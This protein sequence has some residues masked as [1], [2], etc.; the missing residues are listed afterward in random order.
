MCWL[1]LVSQ[2]FAMK[3]S[4]VSPD[5]LTLTALDTACREETTHHRHG[6]PS[7][8][9]F[10]MEIF[11]RAL[12]L[13]A[14]RDT[15]GA[16]VY[17]DEA[18]R[19]VLVSI[20]TDFIKA[21]INRAATR[22]TALD[23]LVQQVW[24][25]FWQAASKGLVF[26]SLEAALTYL[27]LAT[28]ST[29]IENNRRTRIQRRSESLEQVVAALGDEALTDASADPFDQHI[30][31]RFRTRCRE[32][33]TDPLEIQIFWMRHSMGLP[34]REIARE[35][36]RDGVLIKARQMTAR[37]VSDLLERVFN[38]LGQDPEIQD[39]LRSD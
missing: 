6:K 12:L 27:N 13:A 16:P 29:C 36:I 11:R 14:Q 5:L 20:Y 24:L 35:L 17:A 4:S 33:L 15:N 38:R 32:L 9:R 34:P 31:Q 22:T 18:A 39:L 3:S 10:C 26:S 25:R 7:D 2:S 1:A 30:Q 37:A 21:H 23:D 8:P 28:I 19:S